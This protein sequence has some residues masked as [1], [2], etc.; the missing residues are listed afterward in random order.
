MDIHTSFLAFYNIQFKELSLPHIPYKK[1]SLPAK[2]IFMG[3]LRDAIVGS[4]FYTLVYPKQPG[5]NHSKNFRSP[6]R[7]QRYRLWKETCRGHAC[8]PGF[9]EE[10]IKWRELK[11]LQLLSDF[12]FGRNFST[13]WNEDYN[14]KEVSKMLK[15]NSPAF[16]SAIQI[17]IYSCSIWNVTV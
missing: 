7:K 4:Q 8:I 2:K 13:A 3:Y 15:S 17:T 1:L 11:C 10:S 16:L 12:E 6:V 9:C 14:L 5:E